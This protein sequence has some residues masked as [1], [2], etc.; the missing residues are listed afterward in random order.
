MFIHLFMFLV[1]FL[2]SIQSNIYLKIVNISG[3]KIIKSIKTV[4]KIKIKNKKNYFRFIVK[5]TTKTFEWIIFWNINNKNIIW[6]IVYF[7]LA[8]VQQQQQ[9]K[10]Q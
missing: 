4:T 2:S 9:H 6:K 1:W 3:C 8:L 10:S 7:S 5:S